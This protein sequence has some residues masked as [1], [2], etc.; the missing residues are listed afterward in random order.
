MTYFKEEFLKHKFHR[1]EL[2]KLDVCGYHDELQMLCESPDNSWLETKFVRDVWVDYFYDVE[3]DTEAVFYK[4]TDFFLPM[5]HEFNSTATDAEKQMFA[6][7]QEEVGGVIEE[8]EYRCDHYD[9]FFQE[10]K[11]I[12][13]EITSYIY[14]RSDDGEDWDDEPHTFSYGTIYL[15][16]RDISQEWN[17]VEDDRGYSYYD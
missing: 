2:K 15:Y 11:I 4:Y 17:E 13:I 12:S 16:Y 14:L 5:S 7:L 6:R 1:H 3:Q 8:N 10:D 9:I